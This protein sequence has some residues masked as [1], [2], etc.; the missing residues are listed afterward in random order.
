MFIGNDKSK[1][2]R[3][4]MLVNTCFGKVADTY[5][6]KMKSITGIFQV[7]CQYLRIPCFKVHLKEKINNLGI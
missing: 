5:P 4:K 3:C 7:T 1:Q 6:E 2:K